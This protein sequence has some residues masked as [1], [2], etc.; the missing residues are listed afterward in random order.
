MTPSP[1]ARIATAGAQGQ[2]VPSHRIETQGVATAADCAAMVDHVDVEE[3]AGKRILKKRAGQKRSF[4]DIDDEDEEDVGRRDEV[5]VEKFDPTAEVSCHGLSL[6][7]M[8]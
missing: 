8:Q 6:V 7:R 4:L 3:I 5:A 1:P 2:F